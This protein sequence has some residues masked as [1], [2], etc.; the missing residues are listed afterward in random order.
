MSLLKSLSGK[1]FQSWKDDID[2]KAI[3]LC[4]EDKNA[5]VLDVGCGDGEMTAKF[6][7]KISSKRQI[8]GLEGLHVLEKKA[9]KKGIDCRHAD[10]ENKFPLDTNSFDV[11]ISYFSLE[12]LVRVD[13]FLQEIRR[14]LRPGGY[15]IIATDNLSSWANIFSL[16]LGFHPFSL[17]PGLSDVVVGNPLAIRS[18]ESGVSW[19]DTDA[20]NVQ[21][22]DIA[23]TSGHIRVL[24]YQAM[25]DILKYRKFTIHTFIGAGY[26]FFG[27]WASS[28]LSSWD[29]RHAHLLL[30]KI[31][32]S[33]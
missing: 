21:K 18:G 4:Q 5:L 3:K 8:I 16:A 20:K 1:I 11:V 12:H 24:A 28:I 19:S 30:V 29:P 32:K 33:E 26:L 9:K 7:Q 14:V 10:L 22:E 25:I 6:A 27:G 13:L 17:T 31:K 15:A 23:G 2:R